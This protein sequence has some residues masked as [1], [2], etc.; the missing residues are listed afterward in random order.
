[1]EKSKVK[2]IYLP[3]VEKNPQP[4]PY[5]E[6]IRAA[7]Q[8]GTEHWPIWHLFAFR[9][10]MTAHLASFT[11]GVMHEAS[12]LTPGLRELIAA[13]TSALNKCDFCMKS[14]A[15]VAAEL[16][17]SEELVQAVLRDAETSALPEKEKALLRYVAKVTLTLPATGQD[18]IV[19]LKQVGWTDTE[20]YY[21]IMVSALFNFYNR[22]VTASGVQPVSDEGHRLHGKRLAQKG[23]D[24][25][26]RLAG[27]RQEL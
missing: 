26:K 22:W 5:S 21:A 11:Q 19:T 4:G 13:Y 27:L 14:H 20:I 15:A 12:P 9:P 18:D 3:D 2:P 8:A 16:L 1:M 7:Q 10:E 23:Y 6:L 17:G 25:N 24:P